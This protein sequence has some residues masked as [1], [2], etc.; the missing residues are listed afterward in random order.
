[1]SMIKNV[2]YTVRMSHHHSPYFIGVALPPELSE[3][4]FSFKWQLHDDINHSLKP[5]VPHITLL[6]P[7]SLRDSSPSEI[8]PEIRKMAGPH[9]PL[10]FS[11]ETVETFDREVLYIKIYSPELETLQSQL[12]SLL[13]AAAQQPYQQNKYLPH[14]T[15]A[16]VHSP[17]TLD[18]ESLR[19]RAHQEITLPHQITIT[20]L[21]CF[22]QT[23]PREYR[24]KAIQAPLIYPLTFS[25]KTD[26][27]SQI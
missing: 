25:A 17:H 23:H 18:I 21:S 1:M 9:L 4:L 8:L 7:S 26:T 24:A 12:V 13:P 6:H 15:L 2:S 14:I 5:L 16:Q 3:Q 10:T 20:S 27:I 19:R 11:L 22:I